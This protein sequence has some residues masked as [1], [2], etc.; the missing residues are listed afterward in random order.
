[1]NV[2]DEVRS[3]LVGQRVTLPG[4]ITIS[5]VRP[6]E[7]ALSHPSSTERKRW[8]TAAEIT[9]DL[10]FVEEHGHLPPPSGPRW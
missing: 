4:E 6:R 2:R 7:Y 10:L 8:G 1:M 5:R 3:L 9:A